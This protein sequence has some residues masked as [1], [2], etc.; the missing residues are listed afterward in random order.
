[1]DGKAV[2]RRKCRPLN[3]NEEEENNS[4]HQSKKPIK[5]MEETSDK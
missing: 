1:M 4:A 5:E 3:K 2:Q